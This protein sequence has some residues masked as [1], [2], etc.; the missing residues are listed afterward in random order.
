MK[1]K[2][3]IVADLKNYKQLIL[4]SIYRNKQTENTKQQLIGNKKTASIN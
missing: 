3:S 4:L 2:T 1:L